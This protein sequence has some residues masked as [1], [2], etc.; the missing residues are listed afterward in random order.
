MLY[1]FCNFAAKIRVY[2]IYNKSKW[3]YSFRLQMP[4]GIAIYLFR[5]YRPIITIVVLLSICLCHACW[6]N[7][8]FEYLWCL[9]LTYPAHT[10][11]VVSPYEGTFLWRNYEP[12]TEQ[13]RS[14]YASGHVSKYVS[15]EKENVPENRHV[16]FY[17]G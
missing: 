15:G 3:H 12:G 16:R 10:R 9:F 7:V 1:V 6:Q 13:V 11:S 4:G 14:G 8:L 17:R 5:N 2:A